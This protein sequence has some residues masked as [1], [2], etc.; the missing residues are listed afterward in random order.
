M[1]DR[2][3]WMSWVLALGFVSGCS[4]VAPSASAAQPA[5]AQAQWPPM[6]VYKTPT[7]GCCS[8][9]IEHV[10]AAGFEVQAVDVDDLGPA[11]A[12]AGVPFGKGSCHTARV[13]DYFIEGHVPVADIQRLLRERPAGRGLVL[14]GMPLGSPGMELPDGRREAF[15]V[16]LVADDGSTTVWSHHQAR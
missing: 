15:T 10:R 3:R 12:Q 2:V 11:K 5:A 6:T 4:Q 1:R 16:E 14:P 13:G 7:C 8:V 9:W